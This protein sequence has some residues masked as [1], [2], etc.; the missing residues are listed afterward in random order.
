MAWLLSSV[1]RKILA[2]GL[3]E[4][5]GKEWKGLSVCAM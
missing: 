5:L 3:V 1:V 2:A 4:M